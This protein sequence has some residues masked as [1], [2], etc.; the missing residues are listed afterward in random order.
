MYRDCTLQEVRDTDSSRVRHESLVPFPTG[1][2]FHSIRTTT[3]YLI[4]S[5]VIREL[6]LSSVYLEPR[7]KTLSYSFCT[8]TEDP[9]PTPL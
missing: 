2:G 5:S 1:K 3:M 8:G 7:G 6:T 4:R 9:V